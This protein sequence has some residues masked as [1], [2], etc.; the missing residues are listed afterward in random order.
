MT[1]L[2]LT[3]LWPLLNLRPRFAKYQAI[4]FPSEPTS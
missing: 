2:S 3:L 4:N 1:H